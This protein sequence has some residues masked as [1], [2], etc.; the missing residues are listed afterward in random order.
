MADCTKTVEFLREWARMCDMHVDCIGCP[1]SLK[2]NGHD[3]VCSEMVR[4]YPRDSI[5]TVQK[6][7]D[8]HPVLTWEEKLRE[9]LPNVDARSVCNV[10]CPHDIFGGDAPDGNQCLSDMDCD[11]CWSGEYKEEKK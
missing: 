2:Q 10:T 1:M 3:E 5:A 4:N 8:E 6:W 11:K 9:L 7:S